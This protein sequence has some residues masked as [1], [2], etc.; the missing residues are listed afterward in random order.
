[1][2]DDLT[3][4]RPCAVGSMAANPVPVITGLRPIDFAKKAESLEKIM[5]NCWNPSVHAAAVIVLLGF[6]FHITPLKGET[7]RLDSKWEAGSC[8]QVQ[9]ALEVRGELRLNADGQRLVTLPLEVEGRLQ[10]AERI[11]SVEQDPWQ[12]QAIR[13]YSH[14]L[15]KIKAGQGVVN[16][17]LDDNQ[18][19]IMALVKEDESLLFCP[20]QPLRR[21]TLDLIDVQGNSLLVDR[22]LP[23]EPVKIGDQWKPEEGWLARVFG[24]DLVTESDVTARLVSVE[25]QVA[26]LEFGGRMEGSTSGVA[27]EL[28][29]NGKGNFDLEQRLLTWYAVSLRE[30]RAIGHAEPGFEVTA[31]LRMAMETAAEPPELSDSRLAQLP[32]NSGRSADLLSFVSDHAN[33]Q[34]LHDRRWRS[35]LDRHDVSVFRLVDRGELIAQCN[36]SELPEFEAGRHLSLDEFQAD[37]RQNLGEQFG[38]IV[39]ASQAESQGGNRILRVVVAG[40][41]SELSIQWIYYH[42]SDD[43][44]RRAA[45]AFTFE[46][47]LIERF[48]Q[49]DQSL[50]ESFRFRARREPLEARH[51]A[52][53][54][55]RSSR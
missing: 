51:P 2:M 24:W 13:S 40:M 42:I 12:R 25:N 48:G 49:A 55:L 26:L 21:E 19:P 44:G 47:G 38:Q 46:S 4:V 31:R 6:V 34:L 5:R 15:A 10:Y 17:R 36:V 52:E 33:F 28:V 39:E 3:I 11:L 22:L 9:V 37:I 54:G 18:G 43:Q 14:A 50:V 8:R 1:M 53:D 35:M 16:R 7:Y 27:S 20:H 32:T 41:A 30:K 29:L 45:M 23:T